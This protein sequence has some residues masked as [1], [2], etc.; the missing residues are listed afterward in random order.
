MSQ[1]STTHRQKSWTER[2][3]GRPCCLLS[4]EPL[5][6]I[7]LRI[8]RWPPSVVDPPIYTTPGDVNRAACS[9]AHSGSWNVSSTRP[10]ERFGL[11]P[12][13]CRQVDRERLGAVL[14]YELVAGRRH[15]RQ[16]RPAARSLRR[17]NRGD[18][19]AGERNDR[20]ESTS[21]IALLP[22][23]ITTTNDDLS[24]RVGPGSAVTSQADAHRIEDPMNQKRRVAAS[25]AASAIAF[26]AMVTAPTLASASPST[27][28]PS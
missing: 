17:K 11:D 8:T 20:R 16:R 7:T 23:G 15:R 9:S 5:I 12:G 10:V 6:G 25:L 24:R 3:N 4:R 26:A 2:S 13:D 14:A 28:C 21:R 22:T 1:A 18:V 27:G 19:L